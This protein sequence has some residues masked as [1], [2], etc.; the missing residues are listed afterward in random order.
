MVPRPSKRSRST[1]RMTISPLVVVALLPFALAAP[2]IERRATPIY[3]GS[4][5]NGKTY[6]YIIAGGGLTGSVLASRLSEDSS[7]TVLLV[8]AGYN[9]ENN[10]VVSRECFRPRCVRD[11]VVL[12][13]WGARARRRTPFL[14]WAC[15]KRGDRKKYKASGR[16]V[17][18][19]RQTDK[20]EASN[21]QKAFGTWIDWAYQTTAQNTANGQTQTMRSGRALGGSTA[22]NGMA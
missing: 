3:D 8:E 10:D 21:Y 19:R 1:K 5:V 4:Q 22:I 7:K 9:E 11:C 20:T 6:D 17:Q 14:R 12:G 13:V 18:W 2:T 16:W 15:G